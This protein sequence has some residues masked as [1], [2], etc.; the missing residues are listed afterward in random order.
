MKPTNVT[1]YPFSNGDRLTAI[2]VNQICNALDA[3]QDYNDTIKEF[4][5]LVEENTDELKQQ[6]S[7]TTESTVAAVQNMEIMTLDKDVEYG[8]QEIADAINSMGGTATEDMSLV[9]LANAIKE[10]IVGNNVTAKGMVAE[11]LTYALKLMCNYDSVYRARLTNISDSEVTD[12]NTT[13]TFA[14]YLGLVSVKMTS[15]ITLSGGSNFRDCTALTNVEMESL[16]SIS[17]NNTFSNCTNLERV[18]MPAVTII[19][20]ADCFAVCQKI[21]EMT[22]GTITSISVGWVGGFPFINLRKLTIGHDTNVSL[23]FGQWTATRVIAEGQS[24]VD[25]LNANI[26]AHIVPNLYLGG[27]KT[28]TF[29][30]ALYN[31]LT[32]ET[33]KAIAESVENGGRGWTLASA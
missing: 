5:D 19:N 15:L 21:K 30:A 28:I 3:I 2:S 27:G 32:E 24:G 14:Y 25:E 18:Y 4:E 16:Q 8:K 7:A 11:E 9:E 26:M 29:G 12:I 6:I 17:G 20:S 13:S 1:G 33:K 31:V 22:L 23:P 10:T